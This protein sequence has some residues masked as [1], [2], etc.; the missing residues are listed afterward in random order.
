MLLCADVGGCVDGDVGVW[1]GDTGMVDM[2]TGCGVVD[3]GVYAGAVDGVVG[4]FV[5][6]VVVFVVVRIGVHVGVVVVWCRCR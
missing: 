2:I 3:V 5:G 6:G 4:D 1:V